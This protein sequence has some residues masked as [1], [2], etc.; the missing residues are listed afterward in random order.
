MTLSFSS[1]RLQTTF[2]GPNEA[3][4]KPPVSELGFGKHFTDHML[5]IKWTAENGWED[6]Q[7]GPLR[8]FQMHPASKVNHSKMIPFITLTFCLIL[9]Y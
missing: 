1:S 7:I 9:C 4:K 2:G 6:P 5:E 8:P 3:K